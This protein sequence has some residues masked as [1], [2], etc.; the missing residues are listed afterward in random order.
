MS[1]G[2][3]EDGGARQSV[4][5]LFAFA[6]EGVHSKSSDMTLVKQSPS[7]SRCEAALANLSVSMEEALSK[8]LGTHV[9]PYSVVA[10][11]VVNICLCDTW[12]LWGFTPSAA[13]G[14]SIG[15]LAAAYASGI[16]TLEETLAAAVLLGSIAARK[17]GGM[18]HTSVSSLAALNDELKRSELALAAGASNVV[19]T[20]GCDL[21]LA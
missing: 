20:G 4:M 9:A 8:G 16:Y 14:H 6:G 13:C 7:F 2:A 19:R 11:T 12:K 10:T 21:Y 3:I 18:L 17:T 1:T 5:I 15:E